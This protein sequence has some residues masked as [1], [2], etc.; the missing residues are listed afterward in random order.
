MRF[1]STVKASF[2]PTPRHRQEKLEGLLLLLPVKAVKE[3]GI[4]P[5]VRV[6]V[7]SRR[8]LHG[9]A[10]R[11]RGRNKHAVANATHHEDHRVAFKCIDDAL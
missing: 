10:V 6:D 5:Y 9:Q 2:G 8:L 11:C 3:N 1:D 4:F 7:K